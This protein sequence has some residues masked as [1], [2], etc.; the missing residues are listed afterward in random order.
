[1]QNYKMILQ[2]EGTR[3]NGWQ[4]QGNTQNTIQVTLEALLSELNGGIVEVNGSGRT[5]AGVHAMGQCASFKLDKA[6]AC[7]EIKSYLNGKLNK[8]IRI[9]SVECAEPRFHARLNAK[10]KTYVYRIFTG[11]KADVFQRHIAYHHSCNIDIEEIRRA[12]RYFIGEHDF[13]AFCSNKR[14]KKST[15]R[16]IYSIEVDF[17]GE[18]LTLSFRGNGFLYNMVRILSGTLLEVGTGEIKTDDI[19]AILDGLDRQK[20]GVTLP[21]GGLMLLEVEY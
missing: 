18:L 20:A 9:L 1:M 4:K 7:E 8:D 19:P 13:K 15:V 17:D 12:S 2:Y 16:T 3:Y 14:T 11:E 5:D 21:S 6:V 10:A